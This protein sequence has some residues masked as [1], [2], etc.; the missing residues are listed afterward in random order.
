MKPQR[1][2]MAARAAF[3]YHFKARER[4]PEVESPKS[5]VSMMRTAGKSWT[6]VPTRMAVA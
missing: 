1:T 5:S 3:F 6:G 2:V 4:L